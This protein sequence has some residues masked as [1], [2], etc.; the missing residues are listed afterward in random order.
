MSAIPPKEHL[1][2]N[3]VLNVVRKDFYEDFMEVYAMVVST[4]E[5]HPEQVNNEIRGALGDTLWRLEERDGILPR[6]VHRKLASFEEKRRS[7]FHAEVRGDKKAG[8]LLYSLVN[9][10]LSFEEYLHDTYIIPGETSTRIRRAIRL[11][12]RKVRTFVFNLFFAY[13]ATASVYLSMPD[14]TAAKR[15]LTPWVDL[16]LPKVL[17]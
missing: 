7:A 8:E 3:D 1:I 14:P 9:E 12:L 17:D 10:I 4:T 15:I 2:E 13:F 5:T 16:L 6:S 11:G